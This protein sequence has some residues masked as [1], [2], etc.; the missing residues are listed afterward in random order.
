M[1]SEGQERAAW[2]QARELFL[3]I[4]ELDSPGQAREL[5]LL[6][7]EDPQL[8]AWVKRLLGHDDG[9]KLQAVES[10]NA[11]RKEEWGPYQAVRRIGSGGMGEVYLA[12]RIDGEFER[13]VAVKRLHPGTQGEQIVERF[14]RERQTLAR[15]DH[16]YI[17]GLIDGGTSEAG[18]PYLVLEFVEGRQIDDFCREDGLDVPARLE[19]FIKVLRAVQYA[20]D[21][22]IIHRDLKP[23]N[24]LVKADGEPRLLDFG[25]A[26]AVDGDQDLARLTGTGQRLFT[27][28]FASPEQVRG[29]AV[30]ESSDVFSLGVILYGLLCD[31][32]P[33]AGN[34]SAHELERRILEQEP[35]PPSRRR[36][37]TASRTLAGD[38]DTIVLKCL[39]KNPGDRLGSVALLADDLDRFLRGVPILTRA[40]GFV[41]RCVR[42][43]R[44]RPWQTIA[45]ALVVVSL[46]IGVQAMR[47]DTQV[48]KTRA[49]LTTGLAQRLLRARELMRQDRP[50]TAVKEL[51]SILDSLTR[52]PDE[53]QL[54]LESI[55]L[56]CKALLRQ[57]KAAEVLPLLER[58]FALRPADPSQWSAEQ[59]A[60]LVAATA[61]Y[62][63]TKPPEQAIRAAEEAY[64]YTLKWLPPGH[65]A[66]LE[67][68]SEYAGQPGS[69]LNTDQR[70]EILEAGIEEARALGDPRSIHLSSFHV[71]RG[72]I[73][74]DAMRYEEALE[75]YSVAVEIERWHF[76]E[77]HGNVAQLRDSRGVTLGRLGRYDEALVEF[78]QALEVFETLSYP[79]MVAR[80]LNHTGDVLRGMGDYEASL[81]Y[82]RQAYDGYAEQTSPDSLECRKLLSHMGMVQVD[83]E[84]WGEAADVLLASLEPVNGQVVLPAGFEGQARYYFARCLVQLG[85]VELA[86]EQAELAIKVMETNPEQ[87]AATLL[88]VRDFARRVRPSQSSGG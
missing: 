68:M 60:L 64:A 82:L 8:A 40:T 30:S 45:G 29:D 56:L 86:L 21:R 5:R 67:S 81:S 16:K 78:E 28:E 65:E 42:F 51:N 79:M 33:W 69:L 6:Q 37:G 25:I 39:A 27:P 83:L 14:L 17:A 11:E 1:N 75:S 41:G 70:L 44:G 59:A 46:A 31:E 2:A 50:Q 20:H 7:S 88:K 13:E 62:R 58:G 9:P 52:L 76:G 80:V 26:R 55:G 18:E 49:E 15:L 87:H 22:G 57:F 66:R 38:L 23:S 63:S 61:C 19:L 71:L 12:K 48:D 74:Q 53:Q 84:Q 4:S 43:A 85:D 72:L 36:L 47:S 73:L 34:D 32:G 24:I 3:D 10:T 77:G 35:L 54:E